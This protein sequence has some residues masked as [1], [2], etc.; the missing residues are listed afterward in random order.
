MASSSAASSSSS[1][2]SAVQAPAAQAAA[3]AARA[4][5]LALSRMTVLL[6][7][8]HGASVLKEAAAGLLSS[9]SSSNGND[10]VR[11]ACRHFA[12]LGPVVLGNGDADGGVDDSEL[13]A[14]Q[15][16]RLG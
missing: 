12:A 7:E 3:Q 8:R 10:D 15:V 9:S 13:G 1:S 2:A 11:E 16:R 5:L 6:F 4:D 14:A